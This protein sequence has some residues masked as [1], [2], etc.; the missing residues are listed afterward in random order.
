MPFYFVPIQ[1]HMPM[2]PIT[3]AAVGPDTLR[4]AGEVADGVRL[5]GFYTRRYMT[6]VIMPRLAEGTGA[7]AASLRSP[8]GASS[9]LGPMLG[10]WRK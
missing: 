7:P 8:E 5:H 10:Q 2:V 1:L 9:P 4:I 3:I 6:E